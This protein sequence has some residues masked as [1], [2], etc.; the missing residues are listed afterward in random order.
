M[1][2]AQPPVPPARK[3]LDKHLVWAVVLLIVFIVASG[4]FMIWFGLSI[5]SHAV[6]VKVTE[7][8][9]NRKEV[10]VKTPVGNV[11]ITRDQNVNN[12]ELGLPIYP[13]ATRAVDSNDDNS[14]S[15]TL[16]LPG[17]TNLRVAA[18]KFDTLDPVSKVEEY[19]KN[20]LSREKVNFTEKKPGDKVVFEIDDGEQ[21]KV[22]SLKPHDGGTRIDL[23]RVYHGRAEPN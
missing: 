1:S 5:L 6:H 11:E 13:G 14:V 16:G 18:A 20:E 15:L 9:S 7:N 3:P 22:V 4:V 8:G 21:H 10:L 23:V 2:T 12:L 19:Y 17:Q